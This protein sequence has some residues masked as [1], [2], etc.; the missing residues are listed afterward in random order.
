[1]KRIV[2]LLLCLLLILPVVDLAGCAFA[3]SAKMVIMQQF[4]ETMGGMEV[5]D[6]VLSCYYSE[7]ADTVIT[8]VTLKTMNSDGWDAYDNRLKD[9]QHN[10][11]LT[12]ADI[13]D[14][15]L[16][17]L[18]FPEVQTVTILV[19]NDSRICYVVVDGLDISDYLL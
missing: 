14:D 11:I 4:V 1:M 3:D 2:A 19:L 13:M 5:G 12:I 16:E 7:D 18:G 9:S 6:T 10:G 15:S 17:S 8:I